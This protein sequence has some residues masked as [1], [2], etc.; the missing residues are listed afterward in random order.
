[1]TN[2]SLLLRCFILATVAWVTLVSAHY[3]R[4]QF[5]EPVAMGAICEKVATWPCRLRE[6][7][8]FV[9]QKSRLGWAALA[10]VC[11]AYFTN[12]F[13]VALLAWCIACIGL[14]LYTPELSAVA[15]LLAGLLTIRVSEGENQAGKAIHIQ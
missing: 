15:L 9:L 5:I 1:M 6:F 8:I 2:K 3:I 12:S 4:H 13:F 11:V 7:V 14:V 10:L